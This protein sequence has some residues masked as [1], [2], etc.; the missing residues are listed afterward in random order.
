MA[1]RQVAHALAVPVTEA[2]LVPVGVD[3]RSDA[4]LVPDRGTRLDGPFQARGDDARRVV[5][6]EHPDSGTDSF[7]LAPALRVQRGVRSS[8]P[9][10]LA[11][12]RE[13]GDTVTHQH[14][15]RW[16]AQVGHR[17]SAIGQR[18]WPRRISRFCPVHCRTIRSALGRPAPRWLPPA[19]ASNG[20]P[21][22]D[23]AMSSLLPAAPSTRGVTFRAGVTIVTRS[24][25]DRT[26]RYP[27]R[28]TESVRVLRHMRGSV[29]RATAADLTVLGRAWER[30]TT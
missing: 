10:Q 29:N 11:R 9:V 7:G 22:A 15:P 27:C 28:I 21:S 5:P 23:T 17:P 6:D 26:S 18:C 16:R 24:M 14:D 2:L 12:G 30:S 25:P 1:G 8:S 4:E 20:Q 13:V 19:K 3:L